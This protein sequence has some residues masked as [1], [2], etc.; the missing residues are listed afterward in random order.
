MFM[1]SDHCSYYLTKPTNNVDERL[2]SDTK[3]KAGSL[4]A[5]LDRAL[6]YFLFDWENGHSPEHTSANVPPVVRTYR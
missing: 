6:E 1:Y 3:I 5:H 2:E 4:S